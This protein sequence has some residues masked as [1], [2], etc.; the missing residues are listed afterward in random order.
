M[1]ERYP[2]WRQVYGALT[3][4]PQYHSNQAATDE[5]LAANLDLLLGQTLQTVQAQDRCFAALK[6]YIAQAGREPDHQTFV[7]H[8]SAAALKAFSQSSAHYLELAIMR[9]V[10]AQ[11]EVL[12]QQ[13]IIQQPPE[14]QPIIR[15]LLGLT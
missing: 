5:L 3:Q 13:V 15:R 1:S 4:A 10:K 9:S 14:Q 6:A 2:N 11:R 8:A 7:E 12:S